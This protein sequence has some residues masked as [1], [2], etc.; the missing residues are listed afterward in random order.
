MKKIID[1]GKHTINMKT[2]NNKLIRKLIPCY[3]PSIYVKDESETLSVVEWVSKYRGTVPDRDIIWLLCHKEFMTNKELRLFAVWC[4]RE[5]LSLVNN[6]DPRSINAC[7][8]AERYANGEATDEEL[9]AAA[10]AAAGYAAAYW[11]AYPAAYWDSYPA[12]SAARAAVDAAASAAVS[13]AR[14]VARAS[15][16]DKLLTYF[17]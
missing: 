13:A 5:A 17:N 8:V 16:L 10:V 15:Q 7:N 14:A 12:D 4:A 11:A 6:P 9:E 3:D 1:L 2:I